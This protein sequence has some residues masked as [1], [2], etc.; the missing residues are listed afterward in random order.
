MRTQE[1]HHAP[2]SPPGIV[3]SPAPQR[4][5]LRMS[6]LATSPSVSTS[7]A[8]AAGNC[9]LPSPAARRGDRRSR[10]PRARDTSAPRRR[11]P[12]CASDRST[13]VAGAYSASCSIHATPGSMLRQRAPTAK[14]VARSSPA[15][16][17]LR[18]RRGSRPCRDASARA[19]TRMRDI[20]AGHRRVPSKSH[21]SSTR[22]RLG[23]RFCACEQ[24]DDCGNMSTLA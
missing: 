7:L 9:G 24:G 11:A 4:S 8:T 17:L 1:L 23:A 16:S 5:P 22:S 19:A 2:S 20:V 18:V 3:P 10:Q 12:A 15:G 6:L 13:R 21:A 14:S